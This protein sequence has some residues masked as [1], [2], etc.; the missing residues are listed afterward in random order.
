MWVAVKSGE[1]IAAAYNSRDLVPKLVEMG[2]RGKGAV[3]QFV[4]YPSDVI[5]I[6]VG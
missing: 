4:P 1:V 3:V 5:I 2:E 6:G